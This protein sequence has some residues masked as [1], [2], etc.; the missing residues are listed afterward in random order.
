[1]TYMKADDVC[2]YMYILAVLTYMNDDYRRIYMSIFLLLGP[3]ASKKPQ[4]YIYI[5]E[6]KTI[7]MSYSLHNN[8]PRYSPTTKVH[9]YSRKSDHI[10][11]T[12]FT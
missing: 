7:Y 11:V 2:I 9:I 6:K 5:G 3:N 10:Y 4:K 1:M 8:K 12:W